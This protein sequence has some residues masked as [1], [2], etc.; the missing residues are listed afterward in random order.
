MSVPPNRPKYAIAYVRRGTELN[1]Q[2]QRNLVAYIFQLET[3]IA[4][5]DRE[6]ARLRAEAKKTRK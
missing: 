2:G 5:A 1:L 6:I 3:A 4:S